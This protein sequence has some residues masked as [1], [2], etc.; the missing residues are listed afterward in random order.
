M[1]TATAQG[2]SLLELAQLGY[3]VT[4]Q[5]IKSGRIRDIETGWGDWQ[6]SLTEN[7][8]DQ[9][10]TLLGGRYATQSRIATKL[11]YLSSLPSF[12]AFDRIHFCKHSK[13][14]AYCAGQDYPS[15]LSTIRRWFL[16][17]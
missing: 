7:D 12:W 5:N 11:N 8:I 16:N 15:E 6:Y 13:R 14:W 4:L 17:L 1:T 3:D 2:K 9:I 10:C